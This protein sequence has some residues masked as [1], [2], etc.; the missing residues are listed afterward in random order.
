M[1]NTHKKKI[2]ITIEARM[3]S[4][5][6][7]GKVCL[8]LEKSKTVLEILIDRIK[9]SKYATQ[10][11]VATTKN[12]IDDKI[13]QIAKKKGCLFYRGSEKNVLNRL[14][15]AVKY[16]KI[17]S[18]IQL[19]GDNPLIDPLIIDYIANFFI[20][21]YP[22]YDFVTNN[23]LF[24]HTRSVPVGMIVSVFKKKSLQ[25]ITKLANKKDHYEHPTLFFYREGKKIFK[26]KNL[27]MPKKW[28]SNLK[29][30]LT[31]DT[32]EDFIFLKKI[33]KELK[34]VKNFTLI[35]I[36]KLIN[37]NKSYLKINRKI[38]QKIP[39]HLN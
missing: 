38:K 5:R 6:L 23:N 28:C 14:Y 17:D 32:K 22:R 30:R 24:D 12:K 33:Y 11:L 1:I 25:K 3:T 2:I 36:L 15:T 8:E 35:D 31:L 7:P 16:K 21:N 4:S 26:I 29:P 39:K 34:K 18:I 19:T 13:V 27:K 9:K 37:K 20:K 10:I